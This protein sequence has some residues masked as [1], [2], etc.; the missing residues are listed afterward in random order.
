[1]IRLSKLSDYAVVVLS[2]L[3]REQGRVLSASGLAESTGIPEPT[4]AKVLKVLVKG[5]IVVSTR[6]ASG[7][8]TLERTPDQISVR[9]L[10]VALEGPIAVT[11]CLEEGHT[12]CSITHSCPMKGRWNKVNLAIMGTLD[13]MMVSELL[14]GAPVKEV[15]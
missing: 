15:A 6:G 13:R 1:M 8:Y 3:A 10:I 4:V 14:I 9:E 7:G 11:S 2:Q 12:D 5:N